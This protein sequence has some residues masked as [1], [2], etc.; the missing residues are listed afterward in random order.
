RLQELD[1][2]EEQRLQA[3]QNLELYQAKM[4]QAHDKLVRPRSFQVGDLVLVLRR[5]ILAHRKIGGKFEPTWEGPF[6]IEKV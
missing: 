2:L 1:G 5:P 3:Q 6:V 4:A